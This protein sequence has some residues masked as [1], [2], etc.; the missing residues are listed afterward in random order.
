M[1]VN[2]LICQDYLWLAITVLER[3]MDFQQCPMGG[4]QLEQSKGQ[5]RWERL[6][7]GR[8]S[9]VPSFFGEGIVESVI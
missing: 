5:S 6:K 1:A 9:F 4:W 2:K 3:N 8:S 7:A